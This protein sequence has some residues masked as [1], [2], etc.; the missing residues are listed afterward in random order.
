MDLTDGCLDGKSEKRKT[1]DPT[2]IFVIARVDISI[3]A[4]F[5]VTHCYKESVVLRD[6]A[7]AKTDQE[8]ASFYLVM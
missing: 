7:R 4:T 8:S 1:N 5:S 6:T 3:L 2:K